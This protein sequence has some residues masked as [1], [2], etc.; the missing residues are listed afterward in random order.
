MI[1]TTKYMFAINLIKITSPTLVL[2]TDMTR[3]GKFE[4]N[5][6]RVIL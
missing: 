2:I 4:W 3:R 5:P 6:L 1:S